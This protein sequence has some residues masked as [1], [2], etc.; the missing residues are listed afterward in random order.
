MGVIA[1]CLSLD[2]R[3]G[4]EGE[5]DKL[6]EHEEAKERTR[7]G[8]PLSTPNKPQHNAAYPRDQGSQGECQVVMSCGHQR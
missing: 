5:N 1:T 8:P 7:A 4:Q 3:Y 6:N 2:T